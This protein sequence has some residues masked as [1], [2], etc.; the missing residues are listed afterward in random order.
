[1]WKKVEIVNKIFF[2]IVRTA[3]IIE[4]FETKSILLSAILF[5]N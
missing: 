5:Y 3:L 4:I 1:M 2:K